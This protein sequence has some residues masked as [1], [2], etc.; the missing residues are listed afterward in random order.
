MPSPP[1]N[2]ENPGVEE[3]S[4]L[5]P[6]PPASRK[7]A[8]DKAVRFLR[9]YGMVL[10]VLIFSAGLGAVYLFAYVDVIGPSYGPETDW[11]SPSIMYACGKG[12]ICPINWEVP[13]LM[14]FLAQKTVSFD[15]SRVPVEVPTWDL[16]P[17]CQCHRYLLY[18]VGVTWRLFGIS[19]QSIKLYLILCYG[20]TGLLL[21]G[22]FRLAMRRGLSAA[23]AVLV[24]LSPPMLAMLPSVRD[25]SKAPFILSAIL[26]MGY[27]VRTPP[28]PRTYLILS[29]VLGAVVGI[30]LG[31]R[32]DVLIC[33]VPGL[34]VLAFLVQGDPRLSWLHRGA[35]CAL[36]L[37]CFFV[38]G[39]PILT[40]MRAEQGATSGHSVVQGLAQETEANLDFGGASYELLYEPSDMFVHATINTFYRRHGRTEP[41]ERYLSPAYGRAGRAF[42]IRV[43]RTFPADLLARAYA[44]VLA[45]F[46]ILEQAPKHLAYTQ[47]LDNSFVLGM[48]TLYR[49]LAGHLSRFGLVYAILAVL[50]LSAHRL[51][52]AI[53]AALIGF[54]FSGYP[55]ILFQF[56]HGFHLVF[57]ALWGLGLVIEALLRGLIRLRDSAVRQEVRKIL[58]TPR[59][60]WAPPTQRILIFSAAA[61]AVLM[62]PL[63]LARGYQYVA[64]NSLLKTYAAAELEAVATVAE[65]QDGRVLV[66]PATT[67]PGLVRPETL[68][69]MEVP[70]EYLVAEFEPASQPFTFSVEYEAESVA[71]DFTQPLEVAS[72]KDGPEN[73][74]RYFFPVYE[75]STVK[76]PK[77]GRPLDFR[78][79]TEYE[80]GRFV[81]I[82][83]PEEHMHSFRGLYRV[84]NVQDFPFL[85]FLSLPKDGQ[86]LRYYKR[87][88]L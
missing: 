29:G 40:A 84:T 70:S 1:K 85:L 88:G 77:E 51:R 28:K 68:P 6:R 53:A 49:P 67:L 12:L 19:W 60:W 43:L 21:Y 24:L 80:C 20:A 81:G 11:F 3:A 5:F 52:W 36:L 62:L 25:F 44:A 14:D 35:A 39:W 33:V 47:N 61:L 72:G 32:Q 16:S 4:S 86:G 9:G 42:A 27:L 71:S 22:I 15:A 46:R 34:L 17:F 65:A 78:K 13:G 50:L 76:L 63:G 66:R 18:A 75:V 31:F 74:I 30:G 55:S 58:R 59:L 56:R 54:Y 26:L 8:R 57:V 64:V 10:A 79:P 7:L 23:A 41:M 45:T 69:R 48:V 73:T 83:V 2:D 82:A 37:L 38:C 87:I